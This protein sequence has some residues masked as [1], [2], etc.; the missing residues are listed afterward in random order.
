MAKDSH[1]HRFNAP[2]EHIDLPNSFNY[3]FYYTPHKI[4]QLAASQL[5]AYLENQTDFKHNF[6]LPDFTEGMIIGKMFGVLVVKDQND[7]LGFLAGVSGKLGDSNEHL[8]FVPPVYDM[9]SEQSY[10]KKDEEGI[11]ALNNEIESLEKAD[12]FAWLKD[13]NATES[14]L[15]NNLVTD[16]KERFKTKKAERKSKRAELQLLEQSQDI[17][18]QIDALNRESILEQLRLKDFVHGWKIRREIT[19]DKLKNYEDHIR[20]LKRLR[21]EKSNQLQDKLFDSYFFHDANQQQ[22]SL[23]QIFGDFSASKPPAGAGECAA[24]KLLEY[25]Y[26]HGYT[27]IALAEFWWGASPKSEV[28][29]HKAFYPACRG[30]CEPILSHMLQG[31]KVDP[32]PMLENPAEGKDLPIIF[33]D[34]TIIVVNKPAEFLSVPG[35]SIS[36]SVYTR[37]KDAYPDADGPLIVHRL[38]MSTSGILILAKTKQAHEYLQRQF[39]KKTIQK[40][41]IAL[42]NGVID[43]TSGTI[44]LPLRVDLDDRP[45]QM[46]CYEHGKHAKTEWKVLDI[47]GNKTRIEFKPITGRTHQLRVHAAHHLGLNAAILGDDLYGTKSNR[48]HLHAAELTFVH[49]TTKESIIISCPAPF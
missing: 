22:K 33:E 18:D 13:Y 5:Q 39:I 28:R 36:D 14:Q 47:Q 29:Q 34:E 12:Y 3:P 15:A 25:A 2:I 20:D 10:F 21:K 44:E 46:V 23:L 35:K 7:E 16:A 4:A 19:E 37:I 45:R 6:G 43:A 1:L 41:Y 31:L 32:N 24:P 40:K 9:L 17:V 42:L 8:F 48:L 30:K 49:P 11:N 38:D 26:Q 27:P